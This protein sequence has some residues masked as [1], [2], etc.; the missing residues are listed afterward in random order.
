M[1][2]AQAPAPPQFWF[3]R[4]LG[5]VPGVVHGITLRTGGV[6]KAPYTSLN[7]GL[8]VGDR[9]EHVIENRIRALRALG[10]SL[11]DAV[12]GE[13]V[14]GSKVQEV[15]QLQAGAGSRRFDDAVPGV[16]ALVTTTPGI[17]LLSLFADCIPILVADRNGRCVAV[18]HAGWRGTYDG[19]SRNVIQHV[20]RKRIDPDDLFVAIGPG[21]RRC[22][23][24]VSPDLAARFRERFGLTAVHKEQNGRVTLD[25]VEANVRLLTSAGI[26]PQ[27]IEVASDCTACRTDRYFSHRAERGLTGRIA[28]VVAL[29]RNDG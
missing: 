13:Q 22:C 4:L 20:I 24:E 1:E 16:D 6:S 15:T 28:A 7:M 21:I 17:P 23:Y 25:L 3:S 9:P 2:G 27:H 18:A 8:H 14:H 19:I 10:L 5:S 26:R 29:V 12:C 11:D